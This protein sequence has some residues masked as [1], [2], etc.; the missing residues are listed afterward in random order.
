[1]NILKPKSRFVGLVIA[2]AIPSSTAVF[3]VD[4][5]SPN[6]E[7]KLQAI[8]PPVQTAAL[9]LGSFDI[10]PGLS[11]GVTYD[12]NF[13]LAP[14]LKRADVIW[15]VT[16]SIGAVLDNTSQGYGTLLSL[17]Y[18][19]SFVEFMHND[20]ND[21]INQK[22]V[23]AASWV[24]AKLSLGVKQTYEEEKAGVVEVGQRIRT[25]TYRTEVNSKYNLSD[26]M[27]VEL[28]PR[29]TIADSQTHI[30]YTEYAADAF[31]NRL[32]TSK[33]TASIGTSF[34]YLD[35]RDTPPS[36]Q[37][38]E[39][40]LL[41]LNYA[42]SGKVDLDAT[43]GAEFRQF[44]GGNSGSRATPVFGIGGAYRPFE[45]TTLTLEAS[46]HD[47]VSA[48]ISDQNYTSTGIN[49]GIRQRFMDRFFASVNGAYENRDYYQATL[50]GAPATRNDDF[51]LVR[52]MFGAN[53]RKDW[54]AD[55]FYQYEENVSTDLTHKF[56]DYQIGLQT[57]WRM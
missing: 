18:A 38:Y 20:D 12:D 41:K 34:G 11:A 37:E 7:T 55:V 31:L 33:V 17:D 45:G 26:K 24:G 32:V 13:T 15:T 57:S 50:A 39:R 30:G 52:V 2:I 49:A 42:L 19:P 8:A 23:F 48:V 28:N 27:S 3:A 25:T 29:L 46:R 4:P 56:T 9:R 21:S 14:T 1:M 47:Q 5:L 54:T 53:I 44:G 43:A 40:A 51:F 10:H 35:V 6:A 22:A 16:P 36:H